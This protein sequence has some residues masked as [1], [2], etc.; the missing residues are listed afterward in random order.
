MTSI[1]SCCGNGGFARRFTPLPLLALAGIVVFVFVIVIADLGLSLL[2]PISSHSAALPRSKSDNDGF[3]FAFCAGGDRGS[4]IGDMLVEDGDTCDE[5]SFFALNHFFTPSRFIGNFKFSEP[6][7]VV[8]V[9]EVEVVA[10]ACEGG[11]GEDG[12]LPK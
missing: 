5:N 3:L 8:V 9:V 2:F 1:V 6:V 12:G 7:L 4:T 10:A 11:N